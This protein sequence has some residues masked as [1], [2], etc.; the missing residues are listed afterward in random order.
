MKSVLQTIQDGTAYLEK[1]DVESP[2]LNMEHLLAHVLGCKRMQLYLWFDRPL[3]EAELAPLRELTLRRGRRE[4]LQHLLGTVEFMRREFLCDARA[5]IPRP[6]TEE[7][8]E[9][10]TAAAKDAA[11]P[12]SV[13]DMGTGSGVI[14]LSLAL[15]W[16]EAA[17]TLA[18]VSEQALAL[19]REN[20]V[21]LSIPPERLRFVQTDLFS[22]L[23]AETFELVVANLPYIAPEEIPTLSE[24]VQRDPR[25]ALDGGGA[26]GTELMERFISQ[27]LR[28]LSPGGRV[29]MEI[30]HGQAAR[31]TDCL[32]QHGL[33]DVRAAADAAGLERFVFATVPVA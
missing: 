1:R 18:D 32:T 6:E 13:L 28:H 30:G 9:I 8:C 3:T 16:P 7:L 26:A 14:G 20:S 23:D 10:L 12:R 21:R 29:A 17:A 19:A 27:L 15:A 24:E 4:P 31:L 22:A 25:L 5:L 11:P 2:R 33:K